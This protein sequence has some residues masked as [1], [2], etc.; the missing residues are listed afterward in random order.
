MTMPRSRWAD[1]RLVPPWPTAHRRR[2]RHRCRRRPAGQ[3]L[4]CLP[5]KLAPASVAPTLAP[6]SATARQS[7]HGT[8]RQRALATSKPQRPVG[9]VAL[10]RIGTPGH[11]AIT[12]ARK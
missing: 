10:A 12:F 2:C 4:L 7:M 11:L 1:G 3:S 5:C 9:L 6:L 8:L